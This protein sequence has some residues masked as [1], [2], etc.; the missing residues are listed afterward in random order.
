MWVM[1]A[2]GIILF[3]YAASRASKVAEKLLADYDKTIMCDGYGG[4]DSAV[5]KTK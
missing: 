5:A 2:S 3:N 4:Y 1:R